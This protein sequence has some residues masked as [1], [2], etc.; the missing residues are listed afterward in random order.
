MLAERRLLIGCLSARVTAATVHVLSR[1]SPVTLAPTPSL[2]LSPPPSLTFFFLPGLHVFFPY[3]S[4]RLPSA[5]VCLHLPD[6][7]C[8]CS[9][10]NLTLNSQSCFVFCFFCIPP[11]LSCGCLSL[12]QSNP[13]VSLV[14]KERD[15]FHNL[16]I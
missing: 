14:P 1:V 5:A 4:D 8:F 12:N 13:I 2:T 9:P 10:S 15:L 16:F 6:S 7:F 11:S 3:L